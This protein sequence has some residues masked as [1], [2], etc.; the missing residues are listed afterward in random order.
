MKNRYFFISTGLR[1]CYMP[2]NGNHIK[3]KTRREL[4]T[5]LENE[6]YYLRDAGFVGASKK[7]ITTLAAQTWR[8]LKKAKPTYLSMVCPLKPPHVDSYCYG[9]F[10]N[11]SSKREW[12]EEQENG[13]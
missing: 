5:Y 11:M 2:D 6:A 3:V 4:K 10:V 1:G 12:K 8:E 7:N 9:L 13:N